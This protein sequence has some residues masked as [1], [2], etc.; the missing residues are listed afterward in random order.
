MLAFP[1]VQNLELKKKKTDKSRKSFIWEEGGD[2]M[3][4]KGKQ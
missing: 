1:Q 4:G 2:Q 3:E